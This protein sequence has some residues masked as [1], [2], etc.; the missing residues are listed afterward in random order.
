MCCYVSLPHCMVEA[1]WVDYI[2]IGIW[3]RITRR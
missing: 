3:D 1:L 2:E